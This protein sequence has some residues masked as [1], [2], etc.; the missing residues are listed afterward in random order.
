MNKRLAMSLV[1]GTC[2]LSSGVGF[3]ADIK[4]AD[5]KTPLFRIFASAPK[6][7]KDSHRVTLDNQHPLLTIWSVSDVQLARDHKGVRIKLVPADARK[8]AEIARKFDQGLLLL[9]GN[10]RVLEAIHVGAGMNSAV[11]D[12]QYP[13]DDVVAQYVRKRFRLGEFR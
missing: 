13:D 12:F 11:L 10:G 9:E 5:T 1:M 6:Q 4:P 8:F 3:A 2:L 7:G